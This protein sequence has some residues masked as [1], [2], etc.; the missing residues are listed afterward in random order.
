MIFRATFVPTRLE[1]KNS[2]GFRA[3]MCNRPFKGLDYLVG[4]K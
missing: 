2:E 1:S 4:R 3:S